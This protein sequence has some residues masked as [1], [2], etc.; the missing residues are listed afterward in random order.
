V[1]G[2]IVLR[3]H[4]WLDALKQHEAVIVYRLTRDNQEHTIE[5]VLQR[6]RDDM[7]T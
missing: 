7:P 1:I 6:A 5:T 2:T 3:S 4:P